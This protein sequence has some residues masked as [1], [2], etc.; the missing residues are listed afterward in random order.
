MNTMRH[1]EQ[2][3]SRS[4]QREISIADV[5][6]GVDPTTL[7]HIGHSAIS[8]NYVRLA[9][10]EEVAEKFVAARTRL[11]SDDYSVEVLQSGLRAPVEEQSGASGAT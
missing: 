6:P 9:Y 3:L 5:H 4:R 11:L 7:A 1:Y 8:P 2:P 10:G